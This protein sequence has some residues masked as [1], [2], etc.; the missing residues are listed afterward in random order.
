MIYTDGSNGLPGKDGTNGTNG[1]PGNDGKD[2]SNG[3]P[4]KDGINGTD[5]VPGIDGRDGKDGLPGKNGTKGNPGNDGIN[6]KN[7]K[8]GT[9][10]NIKQC[11]WKRLHPTLNYDNTDIGLLKVKMITLIY[12][13]IFLKSIDL[14]LRRPFFRRLR[15]KDWRLGPALG[16]GNNLLL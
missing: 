2:G 8:D 12:S 4:G 6:G 10:R 3:L 16:A 9:S 14:L 13:T 5:G 7:G 15:I 1:V 11:A